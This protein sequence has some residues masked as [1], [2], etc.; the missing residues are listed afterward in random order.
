MHKFIRYIF[1]IYLIISITPHLGYSQYFLFSDQPPDIEIKFLK[2]SIESGAKQSFFNVLKIVNKLNRTETFNLN[3]T[4]PQGW[5]VL[6]KE[7]QEIVLNPYDSIAIPIRISIGS[8]VRGDIGYSVIA[9]ITDSKGNTIKNEYCFVKIPRDTDLGIKFLDRYGYFDQRTHLSNFSIK[10]ENKGNREEIVNFL[11]DSDESIGIGEPQQNQ[12]SLDLTVP[13]F[14]DSLV[15]VKVILKDK[16]INGRNT[17]R[18]NV[19]ASSIDT[20]ISATVWFRN[21]EPTFTNYISETRKPLVVEF[22]AQGLLQGAQLPN[23][24]TNITGILLFPRNKDIYYQYRNFSSKKREDLYENNRMYIGSHIYNW[25]IEI[26][27]SYRSLESSLT[28]RGGYLSY[29]NPKIKAEIIANKSIRSNQINIGTSVNYRVTQTTSFGSG[30]AY[31][32]ITEKDIKSKLAFVTTA[33]TIAKNHRFNFLGAYNILDQL[34]DGKTNRGEFGGE[35]DYSS[36]MGNLKTHIKGKFGSKFYYGN[37]RGR[38]N[39]NFNFTYKLSPTQR[40]VLD[41]Y[42]NSYNIPF[43]ENGISYHQKS[44]ESKEIR[45]DYSHFITPEIMLNGGPGFEGFKWNGVS[46]ATERSFINSNGYKMILGARFR[47]ENTNATLSPQATIARVYITDF[48]KSAATYFPEVL[49]RDKFNYQY[50]SL[51]LRTKIWGFLAAYTSG[52]KSIFEQYT[53]FYNGRQ[54]K[55]LRFMPYID[56]FIYQ[57]KLQFI[58]N[59]S[60]AND[61]VARSTYTNITSLL[62]WYLPHDWRLNVLGTYSIQNRANSQEASQT[63]QTIYLELGI[64]KEFNFSHPRVQYHN[65]S[66]LFFKDFN[67]NRVQESNEPGIKNVLV[68]ISKEFEKDLGDI[69]GEVTSIELLSDNLGRVNFDNLPSGMYNLSYNPVGN[70]A[71]TFSKADIDLSINLNKNTNLNIPFVEKNK[72]FG[73]IVLNRSKLSGLGKLDVS[74]VR[75]TATDSRGRTYSTLTDKIGAFVIFAP[76]TDEYIVNINNI[77]YENFD[78]RQNNFKVQFNGYKQFEVNFVFDEKIRRINFS[79]SSQDAQLASVLQVRRTNLRGTVKDAEST[80]PIRARVNLVNTKT[81]AVLTSI[82]SSSQTGEYSFSFMADDN[83][84]LE[85]LADGYWYHSENLNLNQVTTFLNVSKDVLLK[86]IAIG[87]KIELNIRFGIDKADLT[88][89]SVAELNRL[90]RLLRDNENIKIEIQGHSD[91]LEAITNQTIS[92]DR[93]KIVA[94]Y[95]IENGY[96]NLQIRGFG[97]TKP[98]APNDTEENRALNRRIEIEVISK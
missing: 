29:T 60:Y 65:L 73:N 48:P 93:A 47:F 30:F 46:D 39:A 49:R 10:V 50:F 90:L 33:F 24:A 74:N 8:K 2:H 98:I 97:N 79:P 85:I 61:L 86:P 23:F 3:F 28:G 13:P 54:N 25:Q 9:S 41:G 82:Y 7:H 26:G 70:D 21:L 75:I 57:R 20:T 17:F 66:L 19:K 63:Y 45:L 27:D 38:F 56:A 53:Y 87:S 11:F 81:N 59:I 67:G 51:N 31:N 62:Y 96:S 22:N 71:G 42:Q 43:I 44:S 5:N 80:V 64:K 69:P 95:L 6:G 18:L 32:T 83:Y 78:L 68:V 92:E 72:V 16:G 88:P 15:I 36:I 52:P 55:R 94:R 4:V 12:M 91:D 1:S 77:F 35:M 89:E 58:T 40:L 84:L 34:I 76:V 14:S 37:Y